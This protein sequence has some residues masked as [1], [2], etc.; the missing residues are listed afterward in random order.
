MSARD[1]RTTRVLE[2]TGVNVKLKLAALWTS[3]MLVYVYAD[4]IGFYKPGAIEGILA[5]RVWQLE[6]T[7]GWAFSALAMMTIPSLMVFLSLA[8]PAAAN[9]WT[10]IGVASLFAVISVGNAIG[11][12][13][14]GYFVF[15]AVVEVALL[16]LVI[17]YAWKWPRIH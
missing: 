17:R 7:Q 9:R 5:G 10:S 8:L 14:V 13:W 2:D 11:E 12:S 6:I 15:A 1:E 4:V 3:L 16:S